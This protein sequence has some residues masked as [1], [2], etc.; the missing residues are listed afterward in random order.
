MDKRGRPDRQEDKEGDM[1]ERF[2]QSGREIRQAQKIALSFIE[3]NWKEKEVIA[4]NAPCGTG[5]SAIARAIIEEFPDSV[6]MAPNNMLVDQMS[7]FYPELNVLIGKRHYNCEKNPGLNC[8]DAW[9]SPRHKA[10]DNCPYTKAKNIYLQD[11]VSTVF[12]PISYW[13]CQKDYRWKKPSV[14]IVDEADKLIEM[15]ML[16]SGDSFGKKY[17]PPTNLDNLVEVTDWLRDKLDTLNQIALKAPVEKAF[18][19]L[20]EISKISRVLRGVEISPESFVHQIDD[21][22]DL[23]VFP[24]S[25]PLKLL[26]DL[27]N[28]DKLILMSAT[29]YK[30]DIPKITNKP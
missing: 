3:E 7:R 30:S 22:G 20:E 25:P 17:S 11:K 28:A 15:L 6:Y 9:N 29:L 1:F 14:V 12:N 16:I 2:D 18:K 19:V 26:D 24:I 8:E 4:I 27:L 13:Y 10:C 23:R 5:K 21:K